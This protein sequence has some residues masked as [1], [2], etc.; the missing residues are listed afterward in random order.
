MRFFKSEYIFVIFAVLLVSACSS[1]KQDGQPLQPVKAPPPLVNTALEPVTASDRWQQLALEQQALP[2]QY[3]LQSAS[4]VVP[5]AAQQQFEQGTVLLKQ[6]QLAQAQKLYLSLS[7]Q[8]PNLSGVWVQLANIAQLQGKTGQAMDYL[9]SAVRSNTKNYLAHNRLALLYRQQGQFNLALEHYNF[10]LQSWP[11]FAQARLNR[12]IL[13][14]LYLGNKTQA[15]EDYAVYQALQAQPDRQVKGWIA[16]L[17]RQIQ[18]QE[19]AYNATSG[20]IKGE[21][22]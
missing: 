4:V 8:H 21:F 1:F 20:S 13:H 2:N 14:D 17:E 15:L 5:M 18:A 6:Q 12:G 3:Q 22:K 10:A 7:Q 16:D 11:A 19:K 9:Q